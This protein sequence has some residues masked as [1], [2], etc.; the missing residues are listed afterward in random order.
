MPKMQ[1]DRQKP[2]A[3]PSIKNIP[4]FP[5]LLLKEWKWTFQAKSAVNRP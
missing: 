1:Y 3:R 4:M 5:S 2:D